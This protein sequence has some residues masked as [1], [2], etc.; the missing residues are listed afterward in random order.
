MAEI[1]FM[2]RYGM[3]STGNFNRQ[4]FLFKKQIPVVLTVGRVLYNFFST[5]YFENFQTC[6]KGARIVQ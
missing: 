1:L 2:F 6:C 4:K 5:F 3:F